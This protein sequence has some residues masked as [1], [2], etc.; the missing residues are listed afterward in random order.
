M[1]VL[2]LS[3]LPDPATRC[4]QGAGKNYDVSFLI[5]FCVLPMVQQTTR[6]PYSGDSQWEFC[7]SNSSIIN[8]GKKEHILHL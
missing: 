7:Q 4:N 2:P 6:W 5:S 3:I 1:F 8:G